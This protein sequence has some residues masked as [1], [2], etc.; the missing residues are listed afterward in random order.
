M[1]NIFLSLFFIPF[2]LF[3]ADKDFYKDW[4]TF[5]GSFSD[6]MMTGVNNSDTLSAMLFNS[7]S[8]ISA[9]PMFDWPIPSV[10]QIVP[11][12][13][14]DAG[15]G[16][17]VVYNFNI[18]NSYTVIDKLLV[19]VKPE[20]SASWSGVT[21]TVRSKLFIYVTNVRQVGPT[22]YDKL[23]PLGKKIEDLKERFR[24]EKNRKYTPA[25]IQADNDT[26]ANFL[27]SNKEKIE[28]NATFGRIWNP[29]TMSF[30][31]PL[32]PRAAERL[33]EN[34]IMLYTLLGGVELSA[35]LGVGFAPGFSGGLDT[36]GAILRTGVD[37][38][39]Y[40]KGSYE[41]VVLREK[42]QKP[43]DNFVRVRLGRSRGIGYNLGLGSASKAGID[44]L[45]AG[46]VG[47]L[48]GN[49][50]WSIAGFA[51][52]VRPFRVE[53]DQSWWWLFDQVYRFDL[54]NKDARVAYQRAVLGS[55]KLAEKLA[56]DEKG[57]LREN[58]SVTRLLTSKEKRTIRGMRI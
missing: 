42:P 24:V 33:G 18:D 26:Y 54:N 12:M 14:I 40:F 5:I 34:E 3:G 15:V 27:P 19:G 17:K 10:S 32:S 52:T 41:L 23:E 7:F 56:L 48:D 46:H 39:I 49:F 58:S 47:P 16:R 8:E 38:S 53:W 36:A 45:T 22:D 31:L 57:E 1:K 20:F 37:A 51:I 35:G 30:R 11:G 21:G 25:E 50:L 43:G 29:L 2:T 13:G 4:S 55:F 6:Q 44:D 9:N 28:R